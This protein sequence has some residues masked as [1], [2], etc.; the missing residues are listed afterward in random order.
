MIP[1]LTA[2]A[3]P[4]RLYLALAAVLVIGGF[5]VAVTVL[6]ARLDAAQAR[7]DLAEAHRD[8][9]ELAHT[10]ALAVMEEVQADHQRTLTVMAAS[11]AEQRRRAAETAR[12]L[13][14]VRAAQ[15]DERAPASPA[16][17]AWAVGE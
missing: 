16:C 4:W 6:T 3:S 7:A 9:L 2:S 17:S 10:E 1:L 14:A 8:T 15:P 12:R 11:A 13:E 5:V